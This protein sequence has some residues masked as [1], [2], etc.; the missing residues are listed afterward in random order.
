MYGNAVFCRLKQLA[1][2]LVEGGMGTH[3]TRHFPYG[4]APRHGGG[5]FRNHVGGTLAHQVRTQNLSGFAVGNQLHKA[6]LAAHNDRFS[7][8]MHHHL[9]GLDLIAGFGRFLFGQSDRSD[10]GRSINAG[11]NQR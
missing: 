9:V 4:Q 1:Y 5:K 3:H 10:L 2:R 8:G 7:V 11:R 6:P